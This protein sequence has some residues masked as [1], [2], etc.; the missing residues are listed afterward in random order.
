MPKPDDITPAEIVDELIRM[1]LRVHVELAAQRVLNR[2]L[3]TLLDR[4][5]A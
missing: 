5:T 1:G 2:K 3:Q 4:G